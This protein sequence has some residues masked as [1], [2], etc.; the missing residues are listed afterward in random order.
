VRRGDNRQP[1]G[2][3]G[4]AP[5]ATDSHAITECVLAS[6]VYEEVVLCQR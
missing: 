2:D 1:S 6:R 4:G 5:Y 3:Q